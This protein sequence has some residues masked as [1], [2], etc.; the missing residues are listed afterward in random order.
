MLIFR[1]GRNFL[2]IILRAAALVI[3][4]ATFAS[5]QSY[6]P[7][8]PQQALPD[9]PYVTIEV[10]EKNPDSPG[11]Y[12]SLGP[13]SSGGLYGLN[14]YNYFLLDTGANAILAVDA[15]AGDL[16]AAGIVDEGDFFEYGV[17][18]YTEYNVSA[19]YRVAI[20]GTNESTHYLDG[21][22]GQGVR[23]QYSSTQDLGGPIDMYG[24]AGLVGMP[25]MT[26]RV[27]ELDMTGWIGSS[28]FDVSGMAVNFHDTIP[29]DTTG[30]RLNVPLDTRL[31]FSVEDG[32]PEDAPEGSPVPTYADVPFLDANAIFVD[33]TTGEASTAGG[34]F[35]LDTGAQFSIISRNMAFWLG[36]DE[37]GDGDL[38]EHNIGTVTVGGVGVNKTVPLMAVDQFRLPTEEGIDLIWSIPPEEGALSLIVMDLFINADITGDGLVS[39]ADV[40][41]VEDHFGQTVYKGDLTRGDLNDDGLVDGADLEIVQSQ[42]GQ[43]VALDGVLGVDFLTGGM[44]IDFNTLEMTGMPY[45]EQ[46][47]F[48]FTDWENGN[49]TMSLDL[50]SSWYEGLV[51]LGD[52][53][54]DGM[55]GTADLA[56]VTGNWQ[57]SVTG[58]AAEGD[59]NG[60]GIVDT[61]DLA[62]VTGNWQ[63]GDVQSIPGD[64]NGDGMVTTADLAAVVGNWQMS[65]TGGAA[66][67][68][69]NGDGIVGTADLAAVTGNWQYGVIAVPEPASSVLLLALS[70]SFFIFRR[71]AI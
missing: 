7:L 50:S 30:F 18:G 1:L 52:A 39:E 28:I 59:L 46:I 9:Q 65:V 33:P 21:P 22:D 25:A 62:A 35:L 6:I 41:V 45:F 2:R 16:E 29:A 37:D 8:G 14:P 55:V 57:A 10:F 67:G 34:N 5:A 36:I 4:S 60:D 58:G 27:T 23:I 49:G 32:L 26:G 11:D 31:T 20:T 53:N 47:Y 3:A 43:S 64:A 42:L 71:R 70:I 12:L 13:S 56:A 51:I 19:N 54:G 69:L 40:A 48:D 24:I 61:S 68:D 66:E 15:A 38:F 63:F 17:G 44:E